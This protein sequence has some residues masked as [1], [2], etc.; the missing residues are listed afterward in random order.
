MNMQ[1]KV[2][3]MKRH[4]AAVVILFLSAGLFSYTTL[5]DVG[6]YLPNE[7]NGLVTAP[8]LEVQLM[9]IEPMVKNPTNISVDERGRV[10]VTEA[11]N[12]RPAITRKASNPEGDRIIILEDS[13][14]DGAL[15]K[16]TLFYQGTDLNAPLGICV[17]DNKVIVSQSP[18]VWTFYD[19][20]AD[21]KAD[22]KEIMFQGIS[23]EQH[24][25]GVHAFTF[26]PDGKLYFNFGNSGITLKD[27]N[28]NV[29]LDQDGDEIGPKKYKQGMIFRCD[30]D[31][32]HVEVLADNFR[33][34][35]EVAVDSYG[36]LWQS[37][38]D[39]D[40]NKSTRI[41][42]VMEYGRYGY[43]D[44]ITGASW[45]A[46]RTNIES[47]IPL[48]H[49]HQNDPGVVPNLLATGAGSPTGM[50][51]Y[52]GK[53][54]PQVFQNQMIH[55]E[56]GTN[57]VRAYPVSNNGAGYSAT[58]S[59]ILKG[60]KDQWFRPSDVCVAPDGS[61]IISDWYDPGVGGH[62][63]GDLDKGRIYRIAPTQG[64]YNVQPQDYTTAKG[65]VVAL[66]NPNLT[67]RYLA[68]NALQ[69]MGSKSV[70]E[71]NKLW[72]SKTA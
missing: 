3:S 42:Y 48:Q 66:Q 65:A 25:H 53:L 49:W 11:Y 28:N 30:P 63:A 34:N 72:K 26:G 32:S 47:E 1:S 8:G 50:A 56:A 51:I 58:I 17:L 16:S 33:N 71:L 54:L 10:W 15:D 40:G 39:D 22:R 59:N 69:K 21:G 60:E 35:Y 5:E 7:L 19:D 24:D 45:R 52:E 38:N 9:A 23:G 46:N 27:K 4:S 67:V 37:D 31:G 29:V 68:W 41:S 14:G 6:D 55:A 57:V 43:V 2:R 62:Q 36:S 18:Y 64:K 44:E 20:N 61:L 70:S 12:Y 13:N